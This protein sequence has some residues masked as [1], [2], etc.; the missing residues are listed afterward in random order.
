M[1]SYESSTAT[2]RT[3]LSHPSLQRDK[4]E[5][6][7]DAMASASQDAQD[8]DETI[9]LNGDMGAQLIDESELQDELDALVKEAEDE[10]AQAA[11][12]LRVERQQREREA[13]SRA[14]GTTPS[15]GWQDKWDQAQV[16]KEVQR[17]KD[18]EADLRMRDRWAGSGEKEASVI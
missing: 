14:S 1:K 12:T 9:R 6:T 5:D 3:I 18:A 4:I 10:K 13:A 2:L 17:R 7:M 11:D 15:D 16:D 8:I